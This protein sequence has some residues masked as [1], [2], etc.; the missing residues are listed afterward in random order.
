[1]LRFNNYSMN[2]FVNAKGYYPRATGVRW[3]GPPNAVRCCSQ[4]QSLSRSAFINLWK[5]R[6]LIE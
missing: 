5:R 3:V 6:Q 1:M 4:V 2:R